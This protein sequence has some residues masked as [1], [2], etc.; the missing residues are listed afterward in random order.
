MQPTIV[1][2]FMAII[3]DAIDRRDFPFSLSVAP[4]PA[5]GLLSISRLPTPI[6]QKHRYPAA[7]VT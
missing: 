1:Q 2:A 7:G 6:L 5:A 4:R 3:G